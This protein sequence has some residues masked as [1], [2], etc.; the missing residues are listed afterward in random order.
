MITVLRLATCR[1]GVDLPAQ[2]FRA[3]LLD[4]AHRLAMAGE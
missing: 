1:T 3:A 4:G 2:G